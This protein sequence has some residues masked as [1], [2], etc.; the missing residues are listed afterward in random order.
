M[1]TS[2]KI[3]STKAQLTSENQSLQASRAQ[4]QQQQI[5]H[6]NI[7]N[8]QPFCPVPTPYFGPPTYNP[9]FQGYHYK[10][11]GQGYGR[12]RLQRG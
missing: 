9:N 7:T 6:N 12:G 11:R 5:P 3:K 8:Q 1:N 2:F 4:Q 10:R